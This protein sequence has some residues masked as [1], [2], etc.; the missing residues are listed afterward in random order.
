VDLKEANAKDDQWRGLNEAAIKNKYLKVGEYSEHAC[1][2]KKVNINFK[3][4]KCKYLCL[5]LFHILAP[6]KI[7]LVSG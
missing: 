5:G 4:G 6:G 1:F 7:L 3:V 2:L